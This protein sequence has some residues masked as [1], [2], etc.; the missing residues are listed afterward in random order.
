M[1][2]WG[3][4]EGAM[5][6]MFDPFMNIT[7]FRS[8]FSYVGAIV[9]VLL[10]SLAV[11]LRRKKKTFSLSAFFR[12]IFP[13]HIWAHKS[14]LVD[15][16]LY[17]AYI[18]IMAFVVG[19]LTIGAQFW[20]TQTGHILTSI[21]GAAPE[22]P[23]ETQPL[24]I[25]LIILTLLLAFDFGYWL[26]HYM[27]HRSKILWEFHKVHHSA[28]V[29]TPITE[30][31]VHLVEAVITVTMKAL[32]T[33]IAY[34]IITQIVGKGSP[35][36]GLMTFNMILMAHTITYSHLRHTHINM[37][38]TGIFGILLHSPVHHQIHHS[39]AVEHHDKNM[40]LLFSIWDWMAGTLV[41]PKKREELQLGIGPESKD[42]DGL[43]S[44]S[45]L[46]FVKI[47]RL[48]DPRSNRAQKQHHEPIEAAE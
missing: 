36:L 13:K 33:G 22:A 27:L 9:V 2:I 31:R 46:P 18:P 32:M 6:Q 26:A 10:V 29:L 37:P 48:L 19:S 16:K 1:E 8:L 40:G 7:E 11:R 21:F 44:T 41:V 38:F 30:T 20:A 47:A 14:T 5:R 4:I 15:I 39:S 12:L 17:I 45:F 23:A 28:I 25:A 43:I 3:T 34:A 35:K 24:V 42:Y